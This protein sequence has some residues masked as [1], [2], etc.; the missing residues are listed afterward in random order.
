MINLILD[1][2]IVAKWF[3]PEEQND[4]ALKIKEDFVNKKITI[5][6]PTLIFYELNNILKTAV[7][8]LRIGK[9]KAVNAYEGFLDL[10]IIVYSS[11]DLFKN[12]L[13][14]AMNLDISSYDASYIVLADYLKTP[15]F[16]ADQKLLTKAKSK[17]IRSL[18]D[19]P[20]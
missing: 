9:K 8:S 11:K 14:R 2:S 19:Y 4:I 20:A 5:S 3:L 1:S 15:L 7:K 18:Q 12:T 13:D 10:G 16:T 17:F 6:A